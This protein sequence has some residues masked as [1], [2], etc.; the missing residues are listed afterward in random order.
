MSLEATP[1]SG[2]IPDQVPHTRHSLLVKS[3]SIR[4]LVCSPLRVIGAVYTERSSPTLTATMASG[5]PAIDG[6]EPSKPS[7]RIIAS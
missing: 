1:V 4:R 3:Y 5:C 6:H 2:S 7:W